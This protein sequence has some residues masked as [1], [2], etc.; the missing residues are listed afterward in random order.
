MA[1]LLLQ[2]YPELARYSRQDLEE[3]MVDPVYFQAVF[4]SLERVKVLYE[5]QTDLSMANEAIARHN[6]ELEDSLYTLRSETKEAFDE[7]KRLEARW[8]DLEKEQREVYQRFTPQFLQLRLRHSI[9]AQDDKSESLASEFVHQQ[10]NTSLLASGT[11]TPSNGLE[12]DEFMKEYK[13]LRKVYHKRVIWSDKWAN[14]QVDW[15]D[16]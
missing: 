16:D 13:E 11:G 5:A 9:T 10:P 15:R 4:H 6:L 3:M 1:S 7:A 14:G 8:K 12:I 2:E